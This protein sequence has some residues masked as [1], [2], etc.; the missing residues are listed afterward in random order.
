MPEAQQKSL[1]A[2]LDALRPEKTGDG[3]FVCRHATPLGTRR[4][5]GGQVLGQAL[6]AAQQLSPER[7]AN[8]LHAHFLRR[9]DAETPIH[10]TATKIR[11][12]SHF[13]T[14]EVMA[15]QRGDEPIL[16][17]IASFHDVEEGPTHQI[18][19]DAVGPPQGESFEESLL[20]AM[21]PHG[22]EDA[23][24]I[25]FQLPVEIRSVGPLGIFS[26]DVKPPKARCWIRVRG[27][28]PDDPGLHQ[29][30][31][32]YA[33]DYAIMA[34]ALNPHPVSAMEI[35]SASLDHAVWFHRPFRMDEWLLFELDSPVAA[36]ARAVGRGLLY[37][38]EGQLV[39]SCVQE[40]LVRLR[41]NE[42]LP[43]RVR[44]ALEAADQSR[45]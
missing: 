10:L 32:A 36:G 3:E 14:V 45:S 25:P 44:S 35:Q 42:E 34:P 31:F 37:T 30:L 40:G 12:S 19:M 5:F 6:A 7:S 39:A 9:G 15:R 27:A 20:R 1:V 11:K 41:P 43:E 2:L 28:L 22:F 13:E 33:S 4:L 17:M 8:S 24:E 18:P 38:M 21:T 29:C 23:G 16:Q 26:K